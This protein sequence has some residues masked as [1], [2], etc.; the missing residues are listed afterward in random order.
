MVSRP[1]L[2]IALCAAVALL[3]LACASESDR[4]DEQL[5]Q[6]VS[7]FPGTYDNSAQVERETQSGAHSPHEPITLVIVRV[8]APRL[9]K[10]V[11]YVQEMA[12]NDPNRVMSERMFSFMNDEKSGIIETVYTL[13][14]PVRW[15]DGQNNPDLFAAVT[16][17]DVKSIL[18]CELLWSKDEEKF[19]AAYLPGR[20][21]VPGEPGLT[22]AELT[23]DTLNLGSFQFHRRG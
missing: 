19:S 10:H 2:K 7:N 22:A 15:R 13:N 4:R 5:L 23:P 21:R 16:K 9:G 6:L 12:T 20:C 18:G 17:D 1:P 14:E 11:M 3:A 8:Y